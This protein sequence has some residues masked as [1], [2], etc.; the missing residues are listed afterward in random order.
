MVFSPVGHT[1]PIVSP[2]SS[3]IACKNGSGLRSIHSK[4]KANSTSHLQR[5]P[6]APRPHTEAGA[7]PTN[8]HFPPSHR[9]L[10]SES[11]SKKDW[12]FGHI[13]V[14]VRAR[15]PNS[16]PHPPGLPLVR[17]AA[18]SNMAEQCGPG[19]LTKLWGTAEDLRRTVGF[20]ATLGLRIWW[21]GRRT[22]KKKKKKKI[23]P[24]GVWV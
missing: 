1:L 20:A 14:R 9:A 4:C 15:R 3:A 22:Q 21:H 13:P 5:L 16:R 6:G 8:N 7:S 2:N 10:W 11:T 18:P 12:R 24:S 19:N 23:S 17:R